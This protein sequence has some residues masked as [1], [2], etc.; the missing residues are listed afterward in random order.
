MI[1][2]RKKEILLLFLSVILIIIWISVLK[3]NSLSDIFTFNFRTDSRVKE[4][5]LIEN[6]RVFKKIEQIINQW[7][8]S[9]K[10]L[11]LNTDEKY[12]KLTIRRNPFSRPSFSSEKLNG[13]NLKSKPKGKWKPVILSLK[14]IVWDSES[15]SA[16]INDSILK[17]GDK[18]G[19]YEI[20]KI[21][22]KVVLL[23]GENEKIR[24]F[25][26]DFR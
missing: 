23:E 24:L 13:G 25:I 22:P 4:Q 12:R 26:P 10:N 16:I 3:G 14:G 1:K 20:K 11:P 17:E 19:G 2:E 15:P 21:Y 5:L 6:R 9:Q 7:N 18:I 8:S